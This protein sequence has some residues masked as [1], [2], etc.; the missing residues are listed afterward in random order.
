MEKET[1]HVF[2]LLVAIIAVELD[3]IGDG[4]DDDAVPVQLSG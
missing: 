3:H 4:E 1:Y 2:L